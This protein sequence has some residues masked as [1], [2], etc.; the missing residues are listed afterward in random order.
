MKTFEDFIKDFERNNKSRENRPYLPLASIEALLPLKDQY[1]IDDEQSEAFLQA[2]R[3]VKG[4][5]KNLRT[6]SSGENE[7]TWDIVRNTALRKLLKTIDDEDTELWEDDLPSKEHME[8]ILWA[9]SPE[10]SKIKKNQSK[11]E[12]KLPKAEEK[13]P[14]DDLEE[15]EEKQ[16][17]GKGDKTENENGSRK[18]KSES[19]GSSDSDNDE[20]PKK[21]SKQ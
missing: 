7:P 8:L 11:Y 17:D 14:D 10:A 2:Y 21:K 6:V 20:S 12:E 18:R 19:E 16:Q 15:D 13:K 1:K 9:Y 5:Y 3:S 4:E